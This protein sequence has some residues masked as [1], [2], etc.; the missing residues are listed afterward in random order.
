MSWV[1]LNCPQ[2]SAPLPRVAIWRSVKCASCGALITRTESIVL[3]E[4]FR[5]VLARS[6]AEFGGATG[7]IECGGESY[8]LRDLLGRGEFSE[9][10][11]AQRTGALPFLA[12][13]KISSSAGAADHYARES[14][15]LQELRE[16]GDEAG[17]TYSLQHLPLVMAHGPMKGSTGKYAMVLRYAPGYWGSL[18]ALHDRFPQGLD[19]RHAVWIWRRMLDVLRFLHVRDW[20]HGDVR[21]EH[22]LVHPEYHG[23]RLIGW[24]SARQHAA[25]K[26]RA[27]D[28][29]RSARVIQMLLCGARSSGAL[30]S[31]IPR[32]LAELV[33]K[34]SGDESFCLAN[35]A[36]SIDT[37]LLDAAR[38]AFGAPSFV[39]L[40]V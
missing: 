20:V 39:P 32:E 38:A 7:D 28:L 11:L 14:A 1:A 35:D 33:S 31:H 36:K 16:S 23:V 8:R 27:R 37:L 19:P 17:R 13:I 30:P 24:A 5:K 6:R 22:A 2:C 21:P 3:R 40:N 29:Q 26:A 15:V 34:A 25:P 10:Y 4:S 9:V 12:T 18:A